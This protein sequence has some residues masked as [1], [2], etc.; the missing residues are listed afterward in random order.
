M[1]E[2]EKEQLIMDAW[3]NFAK[4]VAIGYINFAIGEFSIYTGIRSKQDET[5]YLEIRSAVLRGGA[6]K[7][8]CLGEQMHLYAFTVAW[9]QDHKTFKESLQDAK[10]R[11]EWIKKCIMKK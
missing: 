6:K 7:Y 11:K 8:F 3:I 1:C 9:Y 2:N 4:T 10:K 5:D